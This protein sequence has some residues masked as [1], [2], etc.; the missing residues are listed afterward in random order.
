MMGSE[1]TLNLLKMF[2]GL[3]KEEQ[4]KVIRG[5]EL[6]LIEERKLIID[7]LIK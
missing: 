1:S 5:L 7:Q 3:N 2:A 6:A 4:K